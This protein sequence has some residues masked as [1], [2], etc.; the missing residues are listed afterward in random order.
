[1]WHGSPASG[2]GRETLVCSSRWTWCRPRWS[3]EE[4]DDGRLMLRS[5]CTRHCACLWCWRGDVLLCWSWVY[6]FSC[7]C[8]AFDN[9]VVICSLPARFSPPVPTVGKHVPGTKLTSSPLALEQSTAACC[10]CKRADAVKKEGKKSPPPHLRARFRR[11]V[12]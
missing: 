8:A 3:D 1:M 9:C 11:G 10:T 5:V 4:G 12:L 7:A 6:T 2:R